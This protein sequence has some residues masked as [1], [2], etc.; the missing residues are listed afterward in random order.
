MIA[1][2]NTT[3]TATWLSVNKQANNRQQPHV[4]QGFGRIGANLSSDVSGLTDKET[5][6]FNKIQDKVG[7]LVKFNMGDYVCES[8]R[9]L[10]VLGFTGFSASGERSPFMITH[11]MLR[12][13]AADENVYHKQMAWVQEMLAQQNNTEKSLAENKMKAAQEDAERRSNAVRANIVSVVDSFW[14]E[15]KK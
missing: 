13:M 5:E 8:G 2:I 9:K 11:D 12:E 3:S 7:G 1:N 14:R 4:P 6:I 15:N 10:T